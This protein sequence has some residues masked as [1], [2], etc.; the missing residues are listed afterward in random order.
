MLIH[1]RARLLLRQL[2]LPTPIQKYFSQEAWNLDLSNNTNPYVQTALK[3]K[4]IQKLLELDGIEKSEISSDN[5][6][7]TV[8]S[9]EGIDLL[10]RTLGDPGQDSICVIHPTFSAYE[11]WAR[12]HNLKVAR[13]HLEGDE[14]NSLPVKEIIQT[15]PK[16]VFLCTPN[17]PTGTLLEASLIPTLCE[18]LEGFVIVDE[19]YMEFSSAC[20]FLPLLEKYDNLI[21]LRTFS[22]AWGL[23][24]LRCGVILTHPYLIYAL[25]HT[26]LPFGFS[27]VA[28]EKVRDCLENSEAI[29][30]S[31]EV[32]KNNRN[33]LIQALGPLSA[34]TKVFPSE[35][36]FIFIILKNFE[37][38]MTLLKKNHILVADWSA[39]FPKAIRVSVGTP[40]HNALFLDVMR[41]ASL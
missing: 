15:N 21:I 25:R 24:G 6:L 31:W 17:N 34:V 23:A 27:S 41:Q 3:N 12:L 11:H 35:T 37:K 10:L 30:H 39:A 22:K 18:E 1:K 2:S 5:V 38:T 26:Q 28:Q 36:N 20:S 40:E 29:Q 13:I 19:A 16:M 4:Y 14:L 7:F 8:G 32:L 33:H 9:L